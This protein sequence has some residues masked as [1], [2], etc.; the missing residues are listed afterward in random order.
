MSF[1]KVKIISDGTFQ[2]TRVIDLLSGE[3]LAG[4]VEV[5][6]D[7]RRGEHSTAT[8][9]LIDVPI[10]VVANETDILIESVEIRRQIPKPPAPPPQRFDG[11]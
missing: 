6:F 8:I 7:M 2:G 9:T 1:R 4:V 10:E 11:G 3:S 5:S